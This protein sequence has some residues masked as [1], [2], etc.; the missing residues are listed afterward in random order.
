MAEPNDKEGDDDDAA[1]AGYRDLAAER[2]ALTGEAKIAA[3][4][5]EMINKMADHETMYIGGTSQT[6]HLVKGFKHF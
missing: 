1:K 5:E 2:R 4:Q 6:T 3:E